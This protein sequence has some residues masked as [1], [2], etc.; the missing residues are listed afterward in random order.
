MHSRGSHVSVIRSNSIRMVEKEDL[1]PGSRCK[2][3]THRIRASI[4]SLE[5]SVISVRRQRIER[6]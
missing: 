3:R 6:R 4:R 2:I 1:P 5:D